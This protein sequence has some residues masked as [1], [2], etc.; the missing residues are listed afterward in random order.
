LSL[1]RLIYNILEPIIR[2]TLLNTGFMDDP[3]K[4]FPSIVLIISC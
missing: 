3:T 4:F 2:I 1:L